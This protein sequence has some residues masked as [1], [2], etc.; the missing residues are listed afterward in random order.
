MRRISRISRKDIL[1][2]MSVSLVETMDEVLQIALETTACSQARYPRCR[3]SRA[4]VRTRTLRT[5]PNSSRLPVIQT[6]FVI[7]A[8]SERDFPREGIPEVVFAGRSN[9]GKSSLINRLVGKAEVGPDQFDAR[10]KLRASIFIGLT[11]L[12]SSSIC[13]VLAMPKQRKRQCSNGRS[14]SSSIF[15][16]VRQSRWSIQLVD[17]RMPPTDLDLQLVRV[18]GTIEY[19]AHAG[20]NQVRQA[21]E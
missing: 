17:S 10:A 3:I 21:V 19:A 13:P 11:D 15:K 18:A 8:V 16:I 5:E 2:V 6:E 7:S 4:L 1:E 20:C 9:V 14:S 12:S